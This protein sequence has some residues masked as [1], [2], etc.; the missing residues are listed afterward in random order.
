[1]PDQDSPY[2]VQSINGG[3]LVFGPH[4]FTFASD[5][6]EQVSHICG[7]LNAAYRLGLIHGKQEER[8]AN[9]NQQ[10]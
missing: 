9:G 4:L 5:D 6:E 2:F 3:F 10:G 1:M 7:M 8:K